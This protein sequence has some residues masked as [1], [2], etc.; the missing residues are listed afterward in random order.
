MPLPD[1]ARSRAVLIGVDAYTELGPLPAVR[2]NLTALKGLLTDPGLWGLDPGH[3]VVVD[4]PASTDDVL[5]AVHSAA[6]A[7]TDAFLLYFAG[8]GLLS[9]DAELRLAL[10]TAQ[11]ERLYRSVA[12]RDI[13]HELMFTCNAPSRVVILDCCYSGRALDG[14]MGGPVGPVPAAVA[15]TYVMTAS[16]G[17]QPAWAPPG[18]RFTAFT[19]ELVATIEEGVPGACD[20]VG[21]AAV[22]TEVRTRLR[23]KGW[24]EPQ[25]L[26]H[27]DGHAIAL[28]RN[29]AAGAP[30][31]ERPPAPDLAEPG[32]PGGG[33]DG[34]PVGDRDG[35]HAGGPPDD[36]RGSGWRRAVTV[37]A[38]VLLA[39]TLPFGLLADTPQDGPRASPGA[40][41][42]PT[43]SRFGD[44]RTADPCALLDPAVFARFGRARLDRDYGNFDR[45]D[46]LVDI[47][48]GDPVDVVVDLDTTGR[49]DGWDPD[50]RIGAIGVEE[51]PSDGRGCSRRLLAD[52]EQE[53]TVRVLAKRWE[54]TPALCP[55]ADAATGHAAA[56]L[57]RG[58]LPRR[59]PLAAGSLGRYDA[60]RLLTSRALEV[61]PGIDARADDMEFGHF[62]CEWSSTT[63]NMWVELR[64][65]R[66]TPLDGAE[67][68]LTR[69]AGRT[70]VVQPGGEGEDT[71]LIRF[72]HR[73]Y[74]DQDGNTAVE[75]VNVTVGGDRPEEALC[76][77]ATTLATSA[78]GRLGPA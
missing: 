51:D 20:P 66:G 46:V 35:A 15:G 38:G 40:E 28:V 27:K 49:P 29:R 34:V 64:F 6:E 72:V 8:H 54:T 58:T 4:R 77:T 25:Q 5:D 26:A 44:H 47:G 73:S 2:N 55:L 57:G 76:R 37:A 19:G 10:P 41:P 32:A 56:V 30:A 69:I 31:T 71:C 68:A 12:Y 3:C 1:P 42:S 50:R 53:V 36:P 7:A 39:I 70:A 45:C 75:T 65:D 60:C 67:G 17:F 21:M 78:A 52:G 16:A 23:A 74:D 11:S 63:R 43:G 13:R 18:E 22:F 9:P 59:S 48:D 62:A 24:P 14:H 33:G 61:V